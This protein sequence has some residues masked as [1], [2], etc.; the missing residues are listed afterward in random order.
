MAA[1]HFRYAHVHALYAEPASHACGRDVYRVHLA[2]GAWRWPKRGGLMIVR[3]NVERHAGY[4]LSRSERH[5]L[6]PPNLRAIAVAINGT[7][8]R[9]SLRTPSSRPTFSTA[10]SIIVCITSA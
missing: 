3:V 7:P 6:H 4:G 10:F 2:A 5:P 1:Q 8:T 9:N